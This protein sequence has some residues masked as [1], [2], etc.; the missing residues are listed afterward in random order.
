MPEDAQLHNLLGSASISAV[1]SSQIPMIIYP[2][3]QCPFLHFSFFLA[4]LPLF[5][6]ALS[7]LFLL[8]FPSFSDAFYSKSLRS[9]A[10]YTFSFTSGAAQGGGGSFKDRKPMRGWLLRIR[11]GRTNP[12]CVFLE[13]LQWL[14]WSPHPQLLDVAWGNAVV[15]VVVV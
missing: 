5:P 3:E 9:S 2:I 10:C 13:W 14:Q 12:S 11:N 15:V 7:H 4:F 6:S 8:P 1:L